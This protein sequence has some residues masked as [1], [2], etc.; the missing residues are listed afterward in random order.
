[1]KEPLHVFHCA[2]FSSSIDVIRWEQKRQGAVHM[3]SKEHWRTSVIADS[4][5]GLSER[6][7]TI[8]YMQL[9]LKKGLPQIAAELEL[10]IGVVEME[11]FLARQHVRSYL[12]ARGAYV[13]TDLELVPMESS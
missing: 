3:D 7:L 11:N 1:M 12:K 9:E 2:D 5:H 4:L 13:A 10:P 6:Q 8:V